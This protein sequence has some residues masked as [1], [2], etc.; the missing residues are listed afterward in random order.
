M[1]VVDRLVLGVRLFVLGLLRLLSPVLEIPLPR[2]VGAD[3]GEGHEPLEVRGLALGA[4]GRGRAEH[5]Q[6]EPVL[7]LTTF[8]FVNW[9]LFHLRD[10]LRG[11]VP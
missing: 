10:Y 2:T 3:S 8:V 5:Q 7:T 9:Q 11:R 1:V 4:L 6:L